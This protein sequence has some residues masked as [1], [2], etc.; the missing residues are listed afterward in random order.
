MKIPTDGKDINGIRQ[1]LTDFRT[2]I[3]SMADYLSEPWKGHFLS[4][5]KTYDDALEA[6]PPTDAVPAAMDANKVLNSFYCAMANANSLVSMLGSSLNSLITNKDRE[7]A[8]ALNSA[9]D[10]A[11]LKK[12]TDGDLIAKKDLDGLVTKALTD[13]TAAGELLTK[14]M[15]TQLCSAARDQ[16]WQLGEKKVRDELSAKETTVKLIGDRKKLV[17]TAGLPVPD[18][19]LEHL[20]SGTDDEFAVK[21][22]TAESR[23]AKLQQAGIALNS[24]STL[25]ANVWLPESEWNTFEKLAKEMLGLGDPLVA[26]AGSGTTGKAPTGMIV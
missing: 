16:G 4:L 12:L 19:T 15:S 21:R 23:I 10:A 22:T 20:L 6:M 25:R 7:V 2:Q 18:A 11:V 8:I 5:K 17:Q 9:V 24:A 13:K 26:P 3:C 14:E 1:L